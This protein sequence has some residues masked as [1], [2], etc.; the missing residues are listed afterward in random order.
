MEKKITNKKLLKLLSDEKLYFYKVSRYITDLGWCFTRIAHG[1]IGEPV[2]RFQVMR[3]KMVKRGDMWEESTDETRDYVFEATSLYSRITG[4]VQ[5]DGELFK[6]MYKVLMQVPYS[7]NSRNPV[8]IH[9]NFVGI[10]DILSTP[11]KFVDLWIKEQI[12]EAG[13]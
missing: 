9:T 6:G 1:S 4:P 7:R 13:V 10:M 3:P 2:F 12:S 8:E 11:T 5:P